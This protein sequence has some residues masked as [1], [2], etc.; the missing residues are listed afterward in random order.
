M[1]PSDYRPLSVWDHGLVDEQGR[2]LPLPDT[3]RAVSRWL[4]PAAFL[5]VC[6][7]STYNLCNPTYD[8][9]HSLVSEEIFREI[10]VQGA[11]G[12]L[13]WFLATEIASNAET[14]LV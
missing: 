14:Q 2:E 6:K 12:N 3:A 7:A 10:M 11:G 13:S 9:R 5:V 4:Q 8:G 1:T